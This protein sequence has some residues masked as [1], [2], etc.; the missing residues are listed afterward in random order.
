[1]AARPA[2]TPRIGPEILDLGYLV[3]F[4]DGTKKIRGFLRASS[5]MDIEI[6]GEIDRIGVKLWQSG[7]ELAGWRAGGLAVGLNLL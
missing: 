2:S 5:T 3:E 6:L 4:K 7:P 1:M